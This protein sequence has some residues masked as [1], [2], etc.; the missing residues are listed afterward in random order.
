ME[1]REHSRIREKQRRRPYYY[2]RWYRCNH[3]DCRTTLVMPPESI[4]WN[5]NPA[6]QQ[7]RRLR[8][9]Q[10]QLRPRGEW[11]AL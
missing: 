4:V 8:A 2:S 7:L 1:V 9:I 11:G 5:D 3:A 6:A 10:E